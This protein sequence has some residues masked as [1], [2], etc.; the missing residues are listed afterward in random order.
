MNSRVP[1]VGNLR[2]VSSE[3]SPLRSPRDSDSTPRQWQRAKRVESQHAQIH[4]ALHQLQ[5]DVNRLKM[6]GGPGDGAASPGWQG[7]YDPAKSYGKDSL[8]EVLPDDDVVVVGLP[9]ADHGGATVKAV[10]GLWW[11]AQGVGR[12]NVG[13]DEVPDYQYHLPVLP[14]PDADPDS[15]LNFWINIKVSCV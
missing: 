13:T 7:H 4:I 8:V 9:S 3:S 14:R 11:S 12:V 10:P 5:R 6:R 2:V 1:I 15:E